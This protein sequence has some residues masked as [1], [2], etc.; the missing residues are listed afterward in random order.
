[1]IE[2]QQQ[3]ICSLDLSVS[4]HSWQVHS[5]SFLIFELTS[6]NF[7]LTVEDLKENSD[8]EN[9][10]S[11]CACHSHQLKQ[12]QNWLTNVQVE[13]LQHLESRNF[14]KKFQRL[15]HSS[16]SHSLSQLQWQKSVML[17]RKMWDLHERASEE[18]HHVYWETTC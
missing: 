10:K 5:Q 8:T 11:M 14:M 18:L 12:L 6:L 2:T 16:S 17:Y 1:M 4:I 9:L 13:S 15:S 7:N 3:L